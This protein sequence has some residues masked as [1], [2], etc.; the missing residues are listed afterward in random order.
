MYAFIPTWLSDRISLWLI[1]TEEFLLLV[2][3]LHNHSQNTEHHDQWFGNQTISDP[4]IGVHNPSAVTTENMQVG[5]NRSLFK[6]VLHRWSQTVLYTTKFLL[7]DTPSAIILEY[8]FAM[9]DFV[10]LWVTYTIAQ[11]D[12]VTPSHIHY[13]TLLH[14]IIHYCTL[15]HT[16]PH[17]CT[18]FL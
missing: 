15:L 1:T 11:N 8:R 10:N 2:Q 7:C 3:L 5:V 16:T 12:F 14:T 17:C 18:L 4:S 6:V 13:C 9:N